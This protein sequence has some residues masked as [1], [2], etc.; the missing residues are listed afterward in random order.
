MYREDMT[1]RYCNTGEEETQE[2]METCESTATLR[3][4]LNINNEREHI[5]LWRKINSKLLKEHN[6]VSSIEAKLI[7]TGLYNPDNSEAYR[8]RRLGRVGHDS[9]EACTSSPDENGE[10]C[11]L[12][13]EVPRYHA[14]EAYR[15]FDMRVD[16]LIIHP[17]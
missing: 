11:Q 2:H 15:A 12:A 4:G 8:M 6:D 16:V 1:C 5:I 7:K 10:T 9:G 14:T 13:R 17:S 3:E